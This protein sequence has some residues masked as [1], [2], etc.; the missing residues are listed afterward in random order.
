[1]NAWWSFGSVIAFQ[2]KASDRFEEIFQAI[3]FFNE[4]QRHEGRRGRSHCGVLVIALFNEP[5]RRKGGE[6]VARLK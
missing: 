4:P 1:M 6:E 3:A 5:Q 2:E